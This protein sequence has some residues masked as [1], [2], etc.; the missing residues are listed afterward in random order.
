MIVTRQKTIPCGFKAAF[1]KPD[2]AREWT[3]FGNQKRNPD[4]LINQAT[5]DPDILVVRQDGMQTIYL[6][7]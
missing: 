7:P 5:L 2:Y 4:H 3:A 6:R 1:S